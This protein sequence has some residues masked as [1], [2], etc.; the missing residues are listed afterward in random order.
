MIRSLFYFRLF[1]LI[2]FIG[3]PLWLIEKA[4]GSQPD[5]LVDWLDRRLSP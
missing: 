5:W 1:V 3:L 4:R 2:L